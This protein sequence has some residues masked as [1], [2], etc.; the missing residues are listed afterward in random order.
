MLVL[1]VNNRWIGFIYLFNWYL[2]TNKG[3]QLSNKAQLSTIFKNPMDISIDK[4]IN[5]ESEFI[6]NGVNKRINQW[7]NQWIFN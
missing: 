7:I 6:M 3:N 5:F 2:L 1:L 4:K